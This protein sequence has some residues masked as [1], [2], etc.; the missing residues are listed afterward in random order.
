MTTALR[1]FYDSSTTLLFGLSP[2]SGLLHSAFSVLGRSPTAT[3]L[4]YSTPLPQ[5]CLLLTACVNLRIPY[6]GNRICLRALV[7]VADTDGTLAGEAMSPEATKIDI[8]LGHVHVSQEQPQTKDRLRQDVE[9]SVS[10]N[11]AVDINVAG[12]I[13]DAP[14]TKTSASAL[15]VN[16]RMFNSHW[17]GSPEDESEASNGSKE[18]AYF[19]TLGRGMSTPV[20]GQVPNNDKI[21]NTGN[22]IPT[23]LLRGILVTKSSEETSQDHNQVSNN[24]HGDLSSVEASHERQVEQ[25]QRSGQTPVDI[26]CPVDFTVNDGSGGWDMLVV[27]S[28]F[29]LVK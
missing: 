18:A 10:N 11:L 14:H 13:S 24:G 12:A 2:P 7:I 1:L 28:L 15:R 9:N 29:D 25:K 3:H 6:R 17:V 19:A 5:D 26:T 22:G 21:G 16:K 23:P 4:F 27:G 8:S 20:N